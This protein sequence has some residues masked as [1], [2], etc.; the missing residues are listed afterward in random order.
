MGLIM[1]VLRA[2]SSITASIA[3]IWQLLAVLFVPTALC[4]RQGAAALVGAS[5][6]MAVC[7]MQHAATAEAACPLHAQAMV[8]DCNCPRLGCSQ[9][10]NGFMALF[11]PIGVLPSPTSIQVPHVTSNAALLM[12]PSTTSLAPAPVAPPPRS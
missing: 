7:P 9:T 4:C 3:L 10:D 1:R 11:G 6:D 8:H 5:G 2:R 12:S